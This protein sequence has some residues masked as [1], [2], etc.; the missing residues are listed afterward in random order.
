MVH[1]KSIAVH[2]PLSWF[3]RSPLFNLV[4]PLRP[5]LSGWR[6]CRM[7]CGARSTQKNVLQD[8]LKRMNVSMTSPGGKRVSS[9]GR[10]CLAKKLYRIALY[11]FTV[12]YISWLY[13]VKLYGVQVSQILSR[14]PQDFLGC[15]AETL[16]A[17]CFLADLRDAEEMTLKSMK[18]SEL[19]TEAKAVGMKLPTYIRKSLLID[20][21]VERRCALSLT[22]ML[23]VYCS[24]FT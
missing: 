1:V 18:L 8:M 21:L 19:R 4:S 14:T 9:C 20:K 23:W 12:L 3:C 5:N 10:V 16:E 15:I 24:P 6:T 22:W 11:L 2:Q 17:V 7:S 13:F